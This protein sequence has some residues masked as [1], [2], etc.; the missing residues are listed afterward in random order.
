MEKMKKLYEIPDNTWIK[1]LG[2]ISAPPA[3]P[4]IK[5]GD[6]IFFRHVDGMYAL[7]TLTDSEDINYDESLYLVAWALVEPTEKQR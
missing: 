5:D 7:C 3:A 1:V 4:Q 6:V 2:E